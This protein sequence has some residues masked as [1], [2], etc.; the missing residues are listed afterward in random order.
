MNEY[1]KEQLDLLKLERRVDEETYEQNIRN[2]GVQQQREN[3]FVWYPIA[4]RGQDTGRGGYVSLEVERTTHQHLI[5]TLQSGRK[6]ELFSNYNPDEAGAKGIIQHVGGDRLRITLFVD[7]LPDWTRHGKLGIRALFDDDSY[8]AMELA[9]TTAGNTYDQNRLTRI[10]TGKAVPTFDDSLPP[11][12]LPYL[13]PSQ[14]EAVNKVLSANDLAIVHGPPGTG[15]TTTLVAATLELLKKTSK[16][17]LAIAPSNTAID[18]LCERLAQKG[19]RVVRIGN[20]VRVSD[21]LQELTLDHRISVHPDF[22][23]IRELKKRASEFRNMAHK[24]KRNFGPEE[25][26]QR[27]ALFAEA[28]RISHEVAHLEDFITEDELHRAQVI[29]ATPV[30]AYHYAIRDLSFDTALIDEAG[31]ALEAAC[32][33]P[34]LKVKKV[35]LAGDHLQLPPTVKS[36][37]AARKGLTLTLMEKCAGY[38]P[39]ATVLL[40]EQYRMHEKIMYYPS[41]TFYGSRLQAHESVRTQTLFDHDLPLEFIDTAGCGFEE[42]PVSTSFVNPEEGQLLVTVLFD[43]L[44]GLKLENTRSD[45][46]TVGVLSPYKQQVERLKSMVTAHPDY[47]NWSSQLTVN[48]IDGF[49]GQERDI[50]VIGMVRSNSEGKTGFLNETRRMNVAMTRARKKLVVIGDS[51]TLGAQPFYER[52]ITYA[53]ENEFYRSAWEYMDS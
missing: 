24:Y 5:H 36:E 25:R 33:I 37:E 23:R 41:E 4:I 38:H 1:F 52:F 45:E 49:Q 17:L 30:G 29:A 21:E 16:P 20:P 34:I 26:Q 15:K 32:W 11:V 13:N 48:T 8:D 10:L 18:L 22:K 46:I 44:R 12:I 35:I 19:V 42:Q 27:K 39:E 53:Q 14:N 7:E 6:A 50:M 31:Q 43:Y 51:S 3:G 40:N 47:A 9:L 2:T 28:G